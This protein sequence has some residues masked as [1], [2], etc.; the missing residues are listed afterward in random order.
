[1]NDALVSELKSQVII[2]NAL[3][4]MFPTKAPGSDGF[5]AQFFQCHWDLCG[6][7]VTAAVLRVL[8]RTFIVLVPTAVS[9]DDLGQFR[10]STLCNIFFIKLPSRFCHT[11]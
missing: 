4:K 1:M 5:P 11:G 7:E 8:H 10:P 3:F 2:K 6:E 9:T